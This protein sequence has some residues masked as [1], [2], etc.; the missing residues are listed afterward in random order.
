MKPRNELETAI[1]D[2]I[3]EIESVE[4]KRKSRKNEESLAQAKAD[5]TSLYVQLGK[6]VEV[7]RMGQ[8]LWDSD[9]AKLGKKTYAENV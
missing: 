3:L 6:A 7:K 1:H 9:F 5:L 2:K 4:G 8:R